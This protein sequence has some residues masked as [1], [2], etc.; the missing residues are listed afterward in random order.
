MHTDRVMMPKSLG[1]AIALAGVIGLLALS[2]P[3]SWAEP[4]EPGTTTEPAETDTTARLTLPLKDLGFD[5]DMVFY[6]L[7]G[8]VQLSVP[9]PHGLT[10][11]AL[12]ATVEPAINSRA[13]I[14]S[15]AQDDRE[16]VRMNLP[17]ADQ[18]PIVIP[19]TGAEVV[20]DW[21]TFSVRAYLV[22]E[23]GFCV[24]P[25]SPLRLVRASISY[26]GVEQ[27]PITVA[28]FL[29]PVLRKLTIFVPQSPSPAE[30]DTA[31]QLAT[32]LAAHYGQ[33]DPEI[34][35]A[36]LGDG[37]AAPPT[38]PRPQE[39]QIVVKEGPDNGLSLQGATGMPWLLIS[40]TLGPTEES[41]AAL[42][43][44]D[45]SGLALASRA[46]VR[47][48]KPSVRLPGD[49]TTLRELGMPFATSTA[50]RPQVSIPL[51]QTRFGRSIHA[52][53]VHLQGSYSPTPADMG[54]QIAVTIGQET[55]DHWP[56]DGHG[57][58]DRW[59]DVPDRLL[60]RWTALDVT[61]DLAANAGRCGDFSIVG[62][63]DRALTLTIDGDT[64]V[65]SRPAKPPVPDGLRSV[66]QALMPKVQVGVE[67][68]SFGDTARAA[69][70]M[71]GLQ[72]ISSIPIGTVVT[73]PKKALESSDPAV[74]VAADGWNHPDVVLPVSAGS[75]GPITLNAF[76]T[77]GKPTTLS[78]DP[79][80]Q[81]GSLQA[82]FDRGRSLLVATSNG[83]P[84]QLDELLRWLGSDR[85]HWSGI[86]GVAVVSVPGHDPVTVDPRNVVAAGATPGSNSGLG[87]LWWF[88]GAWLAVAVVGAAVIVARSGRISLRR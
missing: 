44:S 9:V 54:G 57:V 61:L 21:V 74:V 35:M 72:R 77:D 15:V 70:I 43:F 56:T 65:Q 30:S 7:D 33:Q 6:G 31:I 28:Q 20:D 69:D 16:I 55:I 67:P 58:I 73:T 32:S 19:L 5:S 78:L 51:D 62:A 8:I 39:R 29:P 53:R 81:F 79:T 12:N 40:G 45:L 3:P 18:A 46:S 36:P 87:W 23:E 37:Q 64:V 48:L 25:W 47:S 59:V 24:Y 83:A 26:T 66:P 42:L 4:D 82:L 71:V 17:T 38:P 80:I 52:V 11:S 49:S 85:K 84:A 86:R 34:V 13:G 2:A 68:R 50:L 75:S 14:I 41:N 63:G 10:P 76:G 88:G 60:Q 27:P 1:R 22:P